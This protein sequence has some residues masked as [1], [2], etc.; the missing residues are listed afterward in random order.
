MTSLLCLVKEPKGRIFPRISGNVGPRNQAVSQL[1]LRS[2]VLACTVKVP[3]CVRHPRSI[4]SPY[5][6]WPLRAVQ[7]PHQHPNGTAE[8]AASFPLLN[9]SAYDNLLHS[10]V[11]SLQPQNAPTPWP[12]IRHFLR[13][14]R[15]PSA[16]PPQL[17]HVPLPSLDFA[18]PMIIPLLPYS[19][20]LPNPV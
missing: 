2:A 11:N 19:R 20:V 1:S 9:S 13:S 4:A 7:N 17:I 6:R 5:L 18:G 3:Y 8:T 12:S 16:H 15:L 10:L 14:P